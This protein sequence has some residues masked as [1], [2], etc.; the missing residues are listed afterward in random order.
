MSNTKA[1]SN[2]TQTLKTQRGKVHAR[3]AQPKHAYMY[4]RQ[5]NYN[6]ARQHIAHKHIAQ[7]YQDSHCHCQCM[8]HTMT[9]KSYRNHSQTTTSKACFIY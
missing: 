5:N 1:K 6:H 2:K 3:N 8:S 4:T 7:T 9:Q